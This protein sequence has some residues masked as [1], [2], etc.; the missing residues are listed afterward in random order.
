MYRNGNQ[1]NQQLRPGT[2]YSPNSLT[3][4]TP[5]NPFTALYAQNLDSPRINTTTCTI[6]KDGPYSIN[7]S[8][9]LTQPSVDR[10]NIRVLYSTTGSVANINTTATTFSTNTTGEAGLFFVYT[11]GYTATAYGMYCHTAT[12]TNLVQTGSP[13]L[14]VTISGSNL[15]VAFASSTTAQT[16]YWKKLKFNS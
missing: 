15:Q 6:S 13:T 16:V 3:L 12:P 4:G 5:A 14:V 11:A 10:A 1:I 2:A 7:G 9:V 8:N